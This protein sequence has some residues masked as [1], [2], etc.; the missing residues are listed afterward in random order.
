MLEGGLEGILLITSRLKIDKSNLG[1]DVSEGPVLIVRHYWWLSR[2]T[3][4]LFESDEELESFKE[5]VVHIS[6]VKL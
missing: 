5:C 4:D 2:S 1:R 6:K 3:V